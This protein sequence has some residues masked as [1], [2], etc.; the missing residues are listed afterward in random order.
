M[1]RMIS[2]GT[3]ALCKSTFDKSGMTK[4]VQ[5]CLKKNLID[6][7]S[8]AGESP[9]LRFCHLVVE[10]HRL[11]EYWMHLKVSSQ[12]RLGD[13]DNFLREVWVE[14][15]GHLSAFRIGRE[16]INMNR[17]LAHI[18]Q[19]GM[20]L[21]YEYDFG[22][23]TELMLK[24]ISEFRSNIKKGEVEMLARNDPPQIKCIHCENLATRICTECMYEEG[25]WLCDSCAED[26]QCGEDM[27]LPVVNSPRTGV[28]GYVG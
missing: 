7:S 27:L 20:R 13:L 11:P 3:C 8:A 25:G 4:H 12:A 1:S 22:S 24:V 19:P 23:T 14:C 5:S 6:H 10:G 26:H 17:K 2:K 28:C 9:S 21:L 18:L 16:E 15:C